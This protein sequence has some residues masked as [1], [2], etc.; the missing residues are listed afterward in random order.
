MI[1]IDHDNEAVNRLLNKSVIEIEIC[2]NTSI[3][4]T[5]N[6]TPMMDAIASTKG[7]TLFELSD[8][9]LD[10]TSRCV[11]KQHLEILEQNPVDGCSCI[12]EREGLLFE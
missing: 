10:F 1:G 4:T 2:R 7:R 11:N 9:K 12:H 5:L 8:T 6:R 3:S